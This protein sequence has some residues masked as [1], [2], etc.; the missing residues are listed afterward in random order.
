MRGLLLLAMLCVL[1]GPSG[2]DETSGE[3]A[4]ATG[5]VPS[6]GRRP[7]HRAAEPARRGLLRSAPATL[8]PF[9]DARSNGWVTAVKNQ[10]SYGTCWAFATAAA[11]ESAL[12]KAGL[13]ENPD[14]SEKNIVNLKGDTGYHGIDGGDI[15]SPIGYLA[16]WQG[17][18]PEELDR[19]PTSGRTVA[20]FG[21]SPELMPCC[22]VSKAVLLPVRTNVTD[23][24]FIKQALLEYGALFVNYYASSSSADDAAG[25]SCETDP[26][27]A[28]D[29]AVTLVGWDDDF[30]I[31]SHIG[32]FIVKNSW[33]KRYGDGGYYRIAYD[34]VTFCTIMG[35]A[36]YVVETNSFSAT[37]A[38]QYDRTCYL[39]DTCNYYS[40]NTGDR[41]IGKGYNRYTADGDQ[42]IVAVG[43]VA[44][45]EGAEYTVKIRRSNDEEVLLSQSG[46]LSEMGYH[47]VRL[48]EPVSLSSG[49]SFDVV[50]EID[51]PYE[52]YES[53]G[54][55]YATMPLAIEYFSK[56]ESLIYGESYAYNERSR[57]Y[58]RLQSNIRANLVLKAFARPTTAAKGSLLADAN[59]TVTNGAEMVSWYAGYADVSS[60]GSTYGALAGLL[61]ANGYTVADNWCLGF[62]PTN[63][64][65]ELSACITITN[66]APCVTASP[67]TDRCDYEVEGRASLSDGEWAEARYD[68]THRFFRVTAKPR[69]AK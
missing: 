33:G 36:A 17:A 37:V 3:V 57:R 2:A 11:L 47:V 64:T 59:S 44:T 27:K 63:A 30:A 53:D 32:A 13:A 65:S 10:R 6:V 31:G 41:V 5:F 39:G 38:Y 28:P 24:A 9:Y 69:G 46:T 4:R 21:T 26:S 29:H 42:E 40:V 14:L 62:D 45:M 1:A 22:Y 20:T 51:I 50:L 18:V 60:H 61:C 48:S 55:T 34:D 8:P 35:P 54:E 49:M 16:R 12:L 15:Y 67:S 52:T 23:N 56:S 19:Y 68:G 66:G 58:V 7:H 43:F 25:T